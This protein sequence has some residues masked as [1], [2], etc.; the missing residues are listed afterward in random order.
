[1]LHWTCSAVTAVIIK[2][3]LFPIKMFLMAL[4]LHRFL[5]NALFRTFTL[6]NLRGF[7]FDSSHIG[8]K[9]K[10][11]QINKQPVRDVYLCMLC[12]FEHARAKRPAFKCFATI[13]YIVA[14]LGGLHLSY[15]CFSELWKYRGTISPPSLLLLDSFY[16]TFRMQTR[17]FLA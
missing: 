14:A 3:L 9:Y 13:S 7:G 8:S 4:C 5:C 11:G 16:S 15:L 2:P 6:G 12:V 10:E 1:M 17:L